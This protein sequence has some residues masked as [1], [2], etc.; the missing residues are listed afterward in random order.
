MGKKLRK[1]TALPIPPSLAVPPHMRPPAPPP[2]V[3]ALSQTAYPAPAPLHS[4]GPP[5][6]HGAGGECRWHQPLGNK[7]CYEREKKKNTDETKYH[8]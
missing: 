3:W 6:A 4:A 2:R 5:H 8:F 1:G 7:V